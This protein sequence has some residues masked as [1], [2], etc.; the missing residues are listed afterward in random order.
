MLWARAFREDDTSWATRSD[1]GACLINHVLLTLSN[2]NTTGDRVL[3]RFISK[4]QGKGDHAVEHAS[5]ED[6]MPSL[7]A[8]SRTVHRQRKAACR[9]TEPGIR[10]ECPQERLARGNLERHPEKDI[11]TFR[12]LR[13]SAGEVGTW[14]QRTRQ[15]E[16]GGTDRLRLRHS[17]K[18]RCRNSRNRVWYDHRGKRVRLSTR[19]TM[20]TPWATALTRPQAPRPIRKK[21]LRR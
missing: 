21:L 9:F 17:V 18:K 3:R 20:V 19:F 2:T 12:I 13:A 8:D 4:R 16:L 5:R 7:A 14:T 15:G 6:R 11:P 10:L 1:I